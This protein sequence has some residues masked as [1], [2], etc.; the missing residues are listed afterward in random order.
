MFLEVVQLC[1]GHFLLSVILVPVS[2]SWRLSVSWWSCACGMDSL[3]LLICWC[4]WWELVI[5]VFIDSKDG[6]CINNECIYF[7]K[8][9]RA[10]A[11]LNL[12]LISLF[13][14]NIYMHW[15]LKWPVIFSC[16]FFFKGRWKDMWS[17]DSEY[18]T[19]MRLMS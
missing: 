19:Q 16:G 15:W 8:L 14:F 6:T 11:Y 17:I 7:W 3:V 9:F 13:I 5:L 1:I 10:F 12:L 2:L 4:G 18:R